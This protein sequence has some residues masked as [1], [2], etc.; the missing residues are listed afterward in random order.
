MVSQ[1]VGLSVLSAKSTKV[2]AGCTSVIDHGKRVA[3]ESRTRTQA[4][5]CAGC[6]RSITLELRVQ[7]VALAWDVAGKRADSDGTKAALRQSQGA[8]FG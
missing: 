7:A 4:V 5:A 8:R 3:T 6:N 2:V 1:R